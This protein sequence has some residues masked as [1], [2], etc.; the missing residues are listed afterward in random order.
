MKKE[1]VKQEMKKEAKTEIRNPNLYNLS[2][3]NRDLIR[4]NP[5]ENLKF[6]QGSDLKSFDEQFGG[7]QLRDTSSDFR[8]RPHSPDRSSEY[9]GSLRSRRRASP[10]SSSSSSPSRR[11][12]SPARRIK[13]SHYSRTLDI[14]AKDE[15]LDC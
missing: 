3:S 6:I 12:R 11:S 13:K 14:T 10:S 15:E 8:Q 5:T 9:S 1:N 7:D 2:R 4:S